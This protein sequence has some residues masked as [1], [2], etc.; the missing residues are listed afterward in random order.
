MPNFKKKILIT[1]GAGFIGSHL[2]HFL[3][4]KY[5]EYQM[6]NLDFLTYAAN[7]D[8]I[9][10]LEKKENYHFIKGNI[11]DFNFVLELFEKTHFDSVLHLAAESHVDTSIK[12]PFIFAKTNILGTLN[13]LES[14]KR[15][16]K[17]LSGK[18]FYHIS[19]DEVFGSLGAEGKFSETNHYRP[20]SPYAASKASSDHFV[21]AYG[22]TYKTPFLISNC[23]NNY[24]PNQHPEKLI[25]K[26]IFSILKNQK[27]PIYGDGKQIRDWLFVKDH[28]KAI[29]TIFHQGTIGETYNIGGNCEWENLKLIQCICEKIDE[30]LE[31][32]NSSKNLI[33]FVKDRKGHDQR[34]A[35]D[36][37]KI[38]TKLGW[39]A[40]TDFEKGIETTIDFYLKKYNFGT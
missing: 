18:I 38:K 16:W 33:T 31:R 13:L 26:A 6:F 23:S 5:P 1:G 3:V 39:E 10:P 12:N 7:Y 15:I 17:N 20:N 25:P 34:Y 4:N 11:C 37:T 40:K 9:K 19:T 30:K 22:K 32:K 36:T 35:M 27:I 14:A 28:C 29:D 8:F 2:L 21:S 24:G